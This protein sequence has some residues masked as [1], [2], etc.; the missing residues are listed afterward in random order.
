MDEKNLQILEFP[1]V[2]EILAGFTSFQVSRE[3][4]NNLA[5]SSDR[6]MVSLLLRQSAEARQLLSQNQGFSIG[7]VR[8]VRQAVA[9][10]ARA[11]TLDPQTLLD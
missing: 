11:K 4:A 7:G 3:L 2:R 5:P 8:D 1:K 10:A 9:M 6:E